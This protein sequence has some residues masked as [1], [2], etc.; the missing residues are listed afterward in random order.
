[1]ND[2]FTTYHPSTTYT[3]FKIEG[4]FKIQSFPS[5]VFYFLFIFSL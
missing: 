1:M 5:K 4:G 3:Y 2:S